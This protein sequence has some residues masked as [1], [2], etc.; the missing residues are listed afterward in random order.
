M[1]VHSLFP[2]PFVLYILKQM[3]STLTYLKEKCAHILQVTSS[4]SLPN[5]SRCVKYTLICSLKAGNFVCYHCLHSSLPALSQFSPLLL[6]CSNV[7]CFTWMFHLHGKQLHNLRISRSSIV[8]IGCKSIFVR[9]I[10]LLRKIKA[11]KNINF[12]K[13]NC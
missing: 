10:Y 9:W 3:F 13:V 6:Q 4:S 11:K 7:E 8:L 5:P 2:L 12:L 1:F